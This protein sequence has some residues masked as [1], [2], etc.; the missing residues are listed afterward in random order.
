MRA[1]FGLF[2]READAQ[3]A[4]QNIKQQSAAG[5]KKLLLK[6]PQ[7]FRLNKLVA[8]RPEQGAIWGALIGLI[9][10]VFFG[11]LIGLAMMYAAGES[12]RLVYP[13][14][15]ALFVAVI[16]AFLGALYS[17]RLRTAQLQAIKEAMVDG[18]ALLILPVRD[19]QPRRLEA[20]LRLY[21]GTL[22]NT[23]EVYTEQLSQLRADQQP[24]ISG[25]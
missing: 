2:S 13:L 4:Y 25:A 6:A 10:G 16:S 14:L 15:G 1:V 8:N 20:S 19:Q 9:A 7:A 24:S 22:V 11:V 12:F 21:G 5:Q 3:A 17:T 18:G 23:I